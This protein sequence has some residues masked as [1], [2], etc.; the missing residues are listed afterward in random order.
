MRHT[1]LVVT[2]KK[3]L[4]WVYI[5]GSYRKINTMLSLFGLLCRLEFLENNFTPEISLTFSLSADPNMTDLLQREH[6]QIL[7]GIGVRSGVGK[8]V[9]FYRAMHFIVHMRGLGIACR[10]SV[11]L[12]VCLSVRL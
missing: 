7:A 2:V 6:P 11:R 8:I 1:F 5:Y 12:S 3:W 9:D 4:K 10:P